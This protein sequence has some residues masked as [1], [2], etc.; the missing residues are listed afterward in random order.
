MREGTNDARDANDV[1][2]DK[3]TNGDAVRCPHDHCVPLLSAPEHPE[4]CR[5]ARSVRGTGETLWQGKRG[6]ALEGMCKIHTGPAGWV[7][8]SVLLLVVMV[9]GALSVSCCTYGHGR[10]RV[11]GGSTTFQS[12]PQKGLLRFFFVVAIRHS[13][14]SP[15]S[16]CPVFSGDAPL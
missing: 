3:R 5:D 2:A 12:S 11:G 6:F 9:T 8:Q 1:F 13:S 4:A 14:S 7:P 16:I 10:V 15:P